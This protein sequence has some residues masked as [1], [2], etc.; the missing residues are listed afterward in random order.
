L[1]NFCVAL[2]LL[3]LQKIFGFVSVN[4]NLDGGDSGGVN[5]S[6]EFLGVVGDISFS[7]SVIV[8]L[9]LLSGRCWIPR[10]TL[11]DDFVWVAFSDGGSD[12]QKRWNFPAWREWSPN[13][14]IQMKNL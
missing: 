2:Y 12:D 4:L 7:L 8:H 14:R 13:S 5:V 10:V 3:S 11:D 9:S 1:I 6:G